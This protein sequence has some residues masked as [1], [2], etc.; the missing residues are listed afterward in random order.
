[1]A[2]TEP[3]QTRQQEGEQG[4]ERTGEKPAVNKRST[5]KVGAGP[6]TNMWR[7]V[8]T[9]AMERKIQDLLFYDQLSTFMN[10]FMQVLLQISSIINTNTNPRI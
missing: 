7:S 5:T 3:W 2:P 9:S 8:T 6:V 4:K 1:M 10:T